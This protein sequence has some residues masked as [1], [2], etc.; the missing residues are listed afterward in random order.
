MS[1]NAHLLTD[2]SLHA[3]ALPGVPSRLR[4]VL[5]ELRHLHGAVSVVHLY[6][7][8][9][10]KIGLIA[11]DLGFTLCLPVSRAVLL[12]IA[13]AEFCLEPLGAEHE[14]SIRY[15]TI[16]DIHAFENGEPPVHLAPQSDRP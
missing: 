15:N 7:V 8:Q 14:A 13:T 5:P 10:L 16:T 4:F 3:N 9:E 2:I 1:A 11:Y 6:H 12:V